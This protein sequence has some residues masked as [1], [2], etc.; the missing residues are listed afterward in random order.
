MT[1]DPAA[2]RDAKFEAALDIVLDGLSLRL[3]TPGS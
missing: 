1:A 2:L 3:G